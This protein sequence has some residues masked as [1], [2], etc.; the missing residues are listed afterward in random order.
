[1][2]KF[3]V[4][5][6]IGGTNNWTNVYTAPSSSKNF[7]HG[8]VYINSGKLYFYLMESKTG[9]A[10]PI[11]LQIYDL[12]INSPINTPPTISLTNPSVNNQ[13]Y[14]LGETIALTA[15]ATDNGSISR[16][17]FKINGSYYQGD[18]SA[19]YSVNWTPTTAGTYTIAARAFEE[20][21][22]SLSTEETRT[23]IVNS[24]T[25]PCTG[26]TNP[27]VNIT[28]PTNNATFNQGQN[29]TINATA[30]SSVNITKVEFYDGT[31][32]VGTDTSS[33]YSFSSSTLSLGT[34]NFT[35]K[36]YSDCNKIT[37]SGV[38]T[39]IINTVVTPP[40]DAPITGPSCG[41]AMQALTFELSPQQRANATSYNWFFR[42]SKESLTTASNGY[43]AT[44][45]PTRGEGEI[46]VGVR[47]STGTSYVQY[48][49]TIT[50]CA[51]RT[52]QEGALTIYPNP[53]KDGI[54]NIELKSK[55]DVSIFITDILGHQIF[56]FTFKNDNET[57][58]K[59]I[60]LSKV[61]KGIYFL[62]L[63]YESKVESSKLIIE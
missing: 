4:E 18:T 19:P 21:Q 16:V 35:A 23:V 10:Q 39:V 47:Y 63:F 56:D 26:V 30:S 45:V 53:S 33:P 15:S 2:E 1:M 32:L 31:A 27:I 60:D 55:T 43:T 7:R 28:S 52:S 57:F 9:S 48:C 22:D 62:N 58:R 12:G 59:D 44:V 34:H 40:S 25:N 5:K 41:N 14:T 51:T 36:A 46:C 49:K 20:G 8:N 24:T 29:V 61:E 50:N 3:F 54:F 17:N 11:Y 6:A 37:L 13:E 38:R 42:G